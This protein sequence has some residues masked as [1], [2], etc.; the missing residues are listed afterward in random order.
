MTPGY[1]PKDVLEKIKSGHIRAV[2][3][4]FTD[5]FGAWQ[6]FTLP[7]TM[8]TEASFTDGHGFDGSS[9]RGW[10][11]INESDMLVVPD[12]STA[13]VDPFF[14]EPTLVM[15]ADVADPITKEDYVR[16][17]RSVARRCESYLQATGLADKAFVGPEPEFFIFDD[18]V[19]WDTQPHS[20]FYRIGS[21]EG[22]WNAGSEEASH[23]YHIRN[24][25]GYLPLPPADQ[26]QDLR[27]EMM[28]TM[29]EVG[30]EM[31][32]QHHEVAS[33]GQAELDM[34]Y[35]SLV[36][37]ADK[38]QWFKYIVKQCAVRAGKTA[39]FM[40]KPLFGDNGSGMHCHFSL[41]KGKSNLFAGSGY[42]GLSDVGRWAIGGLLHH[43]HAVIAFTNPTT[44]SYR[45]LVPHFEA[46]IKLAY[47]SRNRSAGI[48]IPMF[49]SS[50]GAKRFEFRCPDPLANGYL[51]F[52][53]IA[54][55]CIDGIQ[56][57]IDPGDPLD[58]NI[59]DLKPEELDRVVDAPTS[60]EAALDALRKDH[61]FLLR[62]DVF[63]RE[64]IETYL[65]FKYDNE[66][67]V[68]KTRPH[69]LEFA[70]YYDG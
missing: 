22:H 3:L 59:Y 41:W 11:T 49:S 32:R 31:E 40:P 58:K 48:R 66:V 8:V 2:D 4:R 67:L 56:N 9:I 20:S 54:M 26:L 38:L 12:P 27:G 68:M 30:I 14:A 15:I 21:D 44:N 70:M 33:A 47:S 29:E 42:A 52:A 23:G 17:P 36:N 63:S 45:R 6:H 69:P 46:P 34:R 50:P 53:A 18:V 62:G 7:A 5:P 51:A 1:S 55:A 25:G 57:R 61:E 10:K 60:L 19:R 64:L 16:D 24:K 39:T 37:M 65:K 43:A 13:V 28:R 35:D